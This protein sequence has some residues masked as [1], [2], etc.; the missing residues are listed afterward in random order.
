[1][2][3]PDEFSY[4]VP[5]ELYSTGGPGSAKRPMSY[6]RFDRSAEAIRFAIEQLPPLMQRG[7]VMEIGDVRF[8]FTDIRKLYD[9]VEYPFPRDV[10]DSEGA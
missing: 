6:R 5:A 2:R 9:S 8:E 3:A 4:D 1:M 7:T 10:A